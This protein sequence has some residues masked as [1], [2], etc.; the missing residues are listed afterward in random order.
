MMDKLSKAI[1]VLGAAIF[2]TAGCALNSE[3]IYAYI[4]GLIAI[5]GGII[6]G[7]GYGLMILARKRREREM[8]FYY[9]RQK[10]R[11]DEDIIWI[12]EVR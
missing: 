1:M 9:F 7:A 5:A 11:E 8:D 10:V 2:V 3:G 12:E 6:A 4:A